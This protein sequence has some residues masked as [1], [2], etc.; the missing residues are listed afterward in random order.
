MP[1]TARTRSAPATRT[2]VD[3]ALFDLFPDVDT[4]AEQRLMRSMASNGAQFFVRDRVVADPD[5]IGDTFS[6]LGAG[7]RP[8]RPAA[9]GRDR[10]RPAARPAHRHRQP[11]RHLRPA[12]RDDRLRSTFNWTL[13]TAADSRFPELAGLKGASGA[14]STC[15][16]SA[17]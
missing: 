7:S 5:L 1:S 4:P 10:P 15:C 9:Q 17:S 3:Q 14:R 2:F 11:D 16:S 6:H 8:H 13:F 12:G